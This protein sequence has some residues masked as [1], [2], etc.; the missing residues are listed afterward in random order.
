VKLDREKARIDA[1]AERRQDEEQE[2]DAELRYKKWLRAFLWLLVVFVCNVIA[3]IPCLAG[4]S[5][6]AYWDSVGV[7]LL[8]MAIGLLPATALCGGMAYVQATSLRN[9]IVINRKYGPK[10]R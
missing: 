10:I 2:N 4:N 6:H 7:K 8:Y 1:Q 5:L 9:L 3:V